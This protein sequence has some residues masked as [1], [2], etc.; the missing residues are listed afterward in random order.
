MALNGKYVRIE[1]ILE[2]VYTDYGFEDDLE[3]MSAINWIGD[4][5]LLNQTM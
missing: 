4:A 2:R 3:W 5:L 1:N